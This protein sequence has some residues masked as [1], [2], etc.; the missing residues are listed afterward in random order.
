MHVFDFVR[1]SPGKIFFRRR[2]PAACGKWQGHGLI[3]GE[4]T[5]ASADAASTAAMKIFLHH[6]STDETHKVYSTACAYSRCQDP[7]T[8]GLELGDEFGMMLRGRSAGFLIS[9][10]A[11][12]FRQPPPILD[13]NARDLLHNRTRTPL[14]RAKLGRA[15]AHGCNWMDS[16]SYCSAAVCGFTYRLADPPLLPHLLL[17]SEGRRNFARRD[18][19]GCAIKSA[20]VLPF[21]SLLFWAS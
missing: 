20:S 4:L 8:G 18:P 10:P 21:C 13:I 15:P 17:E 5:K 7:R 16:R 19:R 1:R 3:T 6:I 14:A 12:R 9:R 2:A 11:R